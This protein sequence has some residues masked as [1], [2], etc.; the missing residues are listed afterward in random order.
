MEKDSK[1]E[2]KVKE[3]WKCPIQTDATMEEGAKVNYSENRGSYPKGT[4]PGLGKDY[5]K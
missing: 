5:S 2:Q 4:S 3:I 1:I